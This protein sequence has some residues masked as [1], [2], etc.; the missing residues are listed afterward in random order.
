MSEEAWQE[1]RLAGGEH[2]LVMDLEISE[3]MIRDAERERA[4]LAHVTVDF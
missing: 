3:E 4:A 1:Y 2:R